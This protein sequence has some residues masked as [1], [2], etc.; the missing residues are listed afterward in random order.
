M[1]HYFHSSILLLFNR[2]KNN[3]SKI[4]YDSLK[5]QEKQASFFFIEKRL[6][7]REPIFANGKL[8]HF[9]GVLAFPLLKV[10]K[11]EYNC[12][13]CS[14]WQHIN[15]KP[16]AKTYGLK[17]WGQY[18]FLSYV[19]QF[20]ERNSKESVIVLCSSWRW[21]G[22][23][24][25]FLLTGIIKN[26]IFKEVF[27]MSVFMSRLWE[28]GLITKHFSQLSQTWFLLGKVTV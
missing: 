20:E 18:T 15:G 9:L 26:M 23:T 7:L 13:S 24:N 17:K 12:K 4:P 28:V 27:R 21:H 19:W 8:E 10:P 1:F 5:A 22:H 16:D 11:R 25:I 14:K 6:R 2:D 3:Q